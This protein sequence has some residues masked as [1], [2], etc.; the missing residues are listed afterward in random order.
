MTLVT[1]DLHRNTKSYICG[2]SWSYEK[3]STA[4]K[5]RSARVPLLKYASLLA[6][7]SPCVAVRHKA[8]S[9]PAH[10]SEFEFT[11]GE[12]V[13]LQSHTD[14]VVLKCN[15]HYGA[16]QCKHPDQDL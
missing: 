2:K 8:T 16:E 10:L 13:R 7:T 9:L 3:H 4:H 11:A 14:V 15:K 1:K 12:S 5:S 6:Q